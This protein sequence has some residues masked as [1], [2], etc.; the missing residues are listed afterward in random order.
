MTLSATNLA[1]ANQIY[2]RINSEQDWKH[3]SS[4]I[5]IEPPMTGVYVVKI[6]AKIVSESGKEYINPQPFEIHFDRRALFVDTT[7][8]ADGNGTGKNPYISLDAAIKT[9]KAKNIKIINVV[10]NQID[11][12]IPFVIS[13]DLIIQPYKSDSTLTINMKSHAIERKNITLKRN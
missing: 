5:N 11:T 6:E 4:P 8:K 2:Y 3:Y 9:A 7:A 13:S 10:D 12:Y 1:N